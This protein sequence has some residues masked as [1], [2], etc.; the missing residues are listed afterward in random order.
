MFS[1]LVTSSCVIR[2]RVV[3]TSTLEP[4]VKLF[5][6]LLLYIKPTIMSASMLCEYSPLSLIVGAPESVDIKTI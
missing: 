4:F 1:F 5:G 6:G 2:A 3:F